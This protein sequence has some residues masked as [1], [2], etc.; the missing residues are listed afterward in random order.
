MYHRDNITLEYPKSN[1]NSIYGILN[2]IHFPP[3][4]LNIFSLNSFYLASK[5]G[6]LDRLQK[7]IWIL[8]T[9]NNQLLTKFVRYLAKHEVRQMYSINK[10]EKYTPNF[11]LDL[12]LETDHLELFYSNLNSSM[13][14]MSN[15]KI[16]ENNT[17]DLSVLMQEFTDKLDME[18]LKNISVEMF[19]DYQIIDCGSNKLT[20]V[21]EL[22]LKCKRL[23]R[24]PEVLKRAMR[25]NPTINILSKDIDIR[26]SDLNWKGDD[27]IKEV[28]STIS[29]DKLEQIIYDYSRFQSID[30]LEKGFAI[31][32]RICMISGKKICR[33]RFLD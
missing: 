31:S 21:R 11:Q 29:K 6:V 25:I 9:N 22:C 14:F 15:D 12:K 16:M 1:L 7:Y 28:G 18:E 5:L 23:N 27:N 13:L 30:F 10:N 17:I 2:S 20:F 32:K 4:D 3:S 19:G 8:R 33:D 26:L 24:L